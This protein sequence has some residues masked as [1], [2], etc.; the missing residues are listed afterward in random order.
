[1]IETIENI[2]PSPISIKANLSKEESQALKQLKSYSDII[3]KKADKGNMLIVLDIEFYRDKLVLNDHLNTDNY[4]QVPQNIYNKVILKL[5]ELTKKHKACLNDQ[6]IKYINNKNEWKSSNIYVS[7]KI[8]KNETIISQIELNN[9]EYIHMAVPPDL[10]GRPIIAGPACPTQRLSEAL[11]KILSPI[12]I[13]IK[14]FIKDDWDF[15]RKLPRNVEFDCDLYACDIVSLYTNIQHDLG[16]KA[17][18]Y[19]IDKCRDKIPQ[20]FTKEFILDSVSFVLNHNN[21]FFL[22]ICWHQLK[23]TAMGTKFA[24]PY[25]CLVIAYLEETKLY[26][27]L[28]R[29]FPA[30]FCEFIIMWFMRYIDDGFILWPKQLDIKTM[31]SILNNL[32]PSINFTIEPGKRFMKN[33]SHIQELAHLDVLVILQ[34]NSKLSTD[35]YYKETNTHFYLDFHSHHPPH[36]KNNIPYTLAKRIIV[37]CSDDEREKFRLQE[38]KTWL[39]KCNYPIDII[40]QG[41]KNAKLQGPA[42]APNNSKNKLI[43]TS[44]YIN[45]YSHD[46][47]I[48]QINCLLTLPKTNKLREIFGDCTTTTAFKQPPNILRHLTKA[49]FTAAIPSTISTLPRK[50]LFKC[51]DSRCKLCRLYLQEC[52]SFNTYNGFNW[53]IRCEITCN[54]LNVLYYLKC[55][56]CNLSTTYTGKT[57]NLRNRMNNHIS[58]CRLGSST[59]KFDNHVFKCCKT[60]NYFS[61]PYFQLYAFLKVTNEQSLLTYENYLHRRGF[62]SMN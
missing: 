26:I 36:V 46:N 62:D 61:E 14:S 37:F 10:K 21:F 6:E 8:H 47:T 9:T 56:S 5:C 11:E 53:E 43:F 49:S 19:W 2:S 35:I 44:K 55:I 52:S 60:F 1:M 29:Y 22:S 4:E 50:G 54:S 42:P 23:G 59:D 13:Y 41:F 40:T 16:I 27:E 15:L 12:V 20:R 32:H 24:P 18:S 58:S 33:G 45:N 7:P 34:D 51:D 57:N 48:R 31:I 25:A 17:I 28:P 30:P 3:I 39:I 38:L